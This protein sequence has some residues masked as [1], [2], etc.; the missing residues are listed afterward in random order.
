MT[1]PGLNASIIETVNAVFEENVL[2][3]VSVAGEVALAYSGAEDATQR[4]KLC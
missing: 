1:N 3:R 2:S 4:G